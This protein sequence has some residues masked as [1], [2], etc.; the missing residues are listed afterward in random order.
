MQFNVR[1]LIRT[2]FAEVDGTLYAIRRVVL[3]AHQ[4]GEL[5]LTAAEVAVLREETYKFNPS[6]P[7][8]SFV[9]LIASYL[10]QTAKSG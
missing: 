2:F 6:K 3:W 7:N 9:V 8:A 1:Q 4:R 10:R 5:S